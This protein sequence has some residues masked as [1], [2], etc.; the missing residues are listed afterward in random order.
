[1]CELLENERL[2]TFDLILINNT[3]TFLE[4]FTQ[5]T[6]I[7]ADQITVIYKTHKMLYR[8]VYIKIMRLK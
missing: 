2:F 7:V 5:C 4:A 6:L 8:F 1:M 3:Y